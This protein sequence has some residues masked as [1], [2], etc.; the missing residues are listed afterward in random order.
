MPDPQQTAFAQHHHCEGQ[1]LI[2]SE[3]QTQAVSTLKEEPTSCAA[4]RVVPLVDFHRPKC[5]PLYPQH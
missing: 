4:V 2:A 5:Y 3:E 1:L